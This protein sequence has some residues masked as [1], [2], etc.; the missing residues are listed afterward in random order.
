[1]CLQAVFHEIQI[2]ITCKVFQN[3]WKLFQTKWIFSRL[4]EIFICVLK[5][6]SRIYKFILSG[7]FSRANEIFPGILKYNLCLKAVF[8]DR[9]NSYCLESFPEFLETFPDVLETLPEEIIFF[10]TIQ[11]INLCQ[12][13]SRANETLLNI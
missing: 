6:F 10:Q 1:M 3:F 13:F 2:H 5:L 12:S 4:P 8:H 7:N 9:I 11:N